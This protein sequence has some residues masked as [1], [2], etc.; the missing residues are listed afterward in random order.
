MGEL[1]D[2][3]EHSS[4]GTNYDIMSKD[5]VGT[6]MLLGGLA[7]VV[8]TIMP[9]LKWV[10]L[11]E[12]NSSR[13]FQ[14]PDVLFFSAGLFVLCFTIYTMR[15]PYQLCLT[16]SAL[17]FDSSVGTTTIILTNIRSI[18]TGRRSSGGREPMPV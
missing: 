11:V 12:I 9:V 3:Q 14:L 17:V 6:Y 13:G 2:D 1:T 7:G 18:S 8:F 10:G 15:Q 4:Q 5:D 16:E